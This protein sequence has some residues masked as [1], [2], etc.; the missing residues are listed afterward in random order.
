MQWSPT[1][2]LLQVW[3]KGT[4]QEVQF[5]ALQRRGSAFNGHLCDNILDAILSTEEWT[6]E[7]RNSVKYTQTDIWWW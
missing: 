3:I 1:E 2:E 7:S 4:K 6:N 5:Y